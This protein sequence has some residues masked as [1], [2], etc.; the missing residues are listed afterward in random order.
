M[1]C[2]GTVCDV[3]EMDNDRFS[4]AGGRLKWARARRY[5]DAVLFAKKMQL[6][7]VTYRAYENDNNGFAKHALRFA[8]ALGVDARW[9]L[10]GDPS[11]APATIGLE[12]DHAPTMSA[13]AKDSTVEIL[14][15]DLAIAM[16]AGT[17]VDDYIEAEP[18]KFDVG[19]LRSITRSPFSALRL[20]R[21]VGESM[22][23]TLISSD[24]IMM[25]MS[26]HSLSRQDGI[27]WISIHGADGIKRLRPA[28]KTTVMVV[29]DNP[30]VGNYEVSAE[31]II[32][33]GR[34]IWFA[35]AL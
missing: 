13:S 23:P 30:V 34:A 29:S 12:P 25:D 7:P 33:K 24:A 4:S 31:D 15:L 9:L 27:Y 22:S 5:S 6:S 10:D 17:L 19:F 18:V 32:I 8:D 2:I 3:G 21:G 14:S 26:E 16:G 1:I 20:I 11:Y 35:R 28:S